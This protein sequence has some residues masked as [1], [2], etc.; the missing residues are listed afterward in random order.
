MSKPLAPITFRFEATVPPT[1]TPD[2]AVW[3]AAMKAAL[4]PSCYGPPN[5][6]ISYCMGIQY[7]DD[8]RP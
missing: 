5:G 3:E 7:M 2:L 6:S 1:L 4:P 8:S